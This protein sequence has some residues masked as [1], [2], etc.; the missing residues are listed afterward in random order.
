[1]DQGGVDTN[2]GEVLAVLAA[3]LALVLTA[4]DQQQTGLSGVF[5]GSAGALDRHRRPLR[6]DRSKA[7]TI[8]L[9]RYTEPLLA[10]WLRS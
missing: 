10:R 5:V 9:L 3:A 7:R 6:Q 1:M 4:E 2:G 8:A